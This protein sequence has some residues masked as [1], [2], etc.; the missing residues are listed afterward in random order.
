MIGPLTRF[1]EWRA[2]E[3]LGLALLCGGSQAPAAT[4]FWNPSPSANVARYELYYG[5]LGGPARVVPA[6][7]LNSVTLHDLQPGSAYYFF[8]RAVDAEGILSPPSEAAF[9]TVPFSLYLPLPE[10]Y[11]GSACVLSYGEQ[12][13][14]TKTRDLT[15]DAEFSLDDLTP[16]K[17]YVFRLNATNVLAGNLPISSTLVWTYPAAGLSSGAAPTFALFP[18]SGARIAGFDTSTQ[19]SWK[20][21]YGTLGHMIL[22]DSAKYPKGVVLS[23]SGKSYRLLESASENPAA[24]ER[25]TKPGR[26]AASWFGEKEMRV[27]MT[28]PDRLYYR[29]SVYCAD[30]EDTGI[31]Q[32][33]DILDADNLAVLATR[34]M[35]GFAGGA[36][37]QFDVRGRVILRIKPAADL[38][39]TLSAIFF[40]PLPSADAGLVAAP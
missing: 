14:E 9:Y 18:P 16:G 15:L 36:Y 1:H 29:V 26:I 13:G 27:S 3:L 25:S 6:G 2:G 32:T 38:P 23:A 30:F 35:V 22:G 19:G 40:D 37:V 20:G 39:A 12:G 31:G 10:S 17:T 34:T 7:L 8:A 21:K 33:L 11:L 28:F 4:V 24:L 5:Q